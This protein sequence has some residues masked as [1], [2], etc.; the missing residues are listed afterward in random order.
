M[1]ATRSAMASTARSSSA[2]GYARFAKP[3][4]AASAPLI[5]SPVRNISIAVRM[6]SSQGWNCQGWNWSSGGLMRR[7]GG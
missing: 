7:V 2:A 3:F 6:P 4:A 1:S 5:A